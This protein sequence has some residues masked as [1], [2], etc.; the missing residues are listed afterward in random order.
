MGGASQEDDEDVADQDEANI[1]T[2]AGAC[3]AKR[4]E[5]DAIVNVR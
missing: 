2:A 3:R 1:A 4:N 5:D